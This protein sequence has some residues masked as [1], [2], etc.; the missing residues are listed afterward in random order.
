MVTKIIEGKEYWAFRN[1]NEECCECGQPQP[2]QKPWKGVLSL[3]KQN[4]K[5]SND[6]CYKYVREE[7][8]YCDQKSAVEAYKNALSDFIANETR[9]FKEEMKDLE[10]E[11]AN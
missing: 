1:D 9:R 11:L 8:L 10:K 7:N 6:F 3:Y 5:V 2:P 4:I